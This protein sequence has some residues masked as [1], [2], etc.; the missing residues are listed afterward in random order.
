MAIIVVT[1]SSG[2]RRD[3]SASSLAGSTSVSSSQEDDTVNNRQITMR[4]N[5]SGHLGVDSGCC[6]PSDLWGMLSPSA[7]SILCGLHLPMIQQHHQAP[8]AQQV[9]LLLY[10]SAASISN[11]WLIVYA[12]HSIKCSCHKLYNAAIASRTLHDGKRDAALKEAASLKKWKQ[13]RRA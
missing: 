7:A 3:P 1:G 10:S 6:D 9:L 5:T 4:S 8:P 12:R 13:S 11:S 2:S